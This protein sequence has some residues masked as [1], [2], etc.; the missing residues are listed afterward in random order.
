MLLKNY[1]PTLTNNISSSSTIYIY[2]YIDNNIYYIDNNILYI[3]NNKG[4]IDT[5]KLKKM[6]APPEMKHFS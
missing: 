1:Y 3:D 5:F 2:I 6:N 4:F